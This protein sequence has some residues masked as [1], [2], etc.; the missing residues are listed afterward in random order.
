MPWASVSPTTFRRAR[1][2]SPAVVW[3]FAVFAGAIA[4][5][6]EGGASAKGGGGAKGASSSGA[7]MDVPEPPF[8]PDAPG[9]GTGPGEPEP[10]ASGDAAGQGQGETGGGAKA[11][12]A[13]DSG[14]DAGAESGGRPA[15]PENPEAARRYMQLLEDEKELR[16]GDR[17]LYRVLEE[18]EPAEPVFVNDKG[19]VSL[20][21]I[22][23]V[24]ARGKTPQELA[25]D[26]KQKLEQTYFPR[27]TVIFKFQF[28]SDSRGEVNVAGAV[29]QQGS[30]SIPT[31]KILTV[32]NAIIK[33]GGMT[34]DADPRK[35]VLIRRG[36][37]DGKER[38]FKVNVQ[39]ILEAGDLAE[40]MP[41][42][43][44]DVVMVPRG[45]RGGGTAY[46]VGAV[47]SPGIIQ[48]P[49]GGGLTVS[50]A[51]L[52]RGGFT[53]F[54]KKTNVKLIRGGENGENSEKSVEERTKT[55][56]VKKI[57]EEGERQRDLPVQ[58]D[59]IIRVEEKL[60]AF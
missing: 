11:K 30:Y 5:A 27:A 9:S 34:P 43:A 38:R 8:D 21:L 51:I 58:P 12:G 3:A 48:V 15:V 45:K 26:V 28:A 54:A 40:D 41:V 35:V 52:Q 47:G 59:D 56:N 50:K 17:L 1:R 10:K 31:D 19:E 29:R 44:G 49:P 60:I 7:P 13:S 18:R 23:N 53:R 32:S 14:P 39:A 6:E 42:Q 20:P 22:G 24:P 55:V 37:D 4:A 2:L 16:T 57:L 33:A 36:Q 25:R 46:V